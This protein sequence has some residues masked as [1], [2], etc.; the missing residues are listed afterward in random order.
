[1]VLKVRRVAVVL[2]C[3]LRPTGRQV[4]T[5]LLEMMVWR[6]DRRPLPEPMAQ[7]ERQELMVRVERP[8]QPE[9]MALQ[10]RAKELRV[11]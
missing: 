8:G 3:R 7:M 5:E 11:E 9:R 6:P 2:R 10:Q 1:M 4:R